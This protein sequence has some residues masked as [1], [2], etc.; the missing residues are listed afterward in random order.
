[1]TLTA[2]HSL[3][4]PPFGGF[5]VYASLSGF[6]SVFHVLDP[7]LLLKLLENGIDLAKV[8]CADCYRCAESDKLAEGI[9]VIVARTG[10]IMNW[11]DYIVADPAILAGKPAVKGTRLSVDFLLGLLEQ[12]WTKEELFDSYPGLS[13]EALRAVFAYVR[14]CMADISFV[15]LETA[16]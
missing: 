9:R 5:F 2:S 11:K 1:M 7:G 4:R 12:G 10:E 3:S 6:E 8:L 16:T 15:P 13:P 14:E